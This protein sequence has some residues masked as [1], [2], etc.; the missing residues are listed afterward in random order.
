MCP[1]LSEFLDSPDKIVINPANLAEDKDGNSVHSSD[2]RAVRFC[3]I[4]AMYAMEMPDQRISGC[5]N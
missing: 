3:L 4:G 1:T 2:K 5:P